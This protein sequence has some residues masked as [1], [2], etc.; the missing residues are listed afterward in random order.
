MPKYKTDRPF[1]EQ[2]L[3]NMDVI[4]DPNPSLFVDQ[5]DESYVVE[6]FIN[7]SERDALSKYFNDNFD[8]IGDNINDHVLHITYPMLK[9]EIADIVKPK[10]MEHFG[11][12]VVFYSDVAK[13]DPMSVGDQFFLSVQPYGLH[14]DAVT[15][16]NGYRPY[17]DIIIPI[18]LDSIEET[19]YVTFNQRYRGRATHFMR[20]R[21]KGSFANYANVIR[22]MSY[23]EYGVEGTEHNKK[24]LAI[25]EKI[26]PSHIPMSI[27]EDLSIEKI[28]KWK[29]KDAIIHDSSVLHAPADFRT[30]GAK[31]KTGI[32][33][34]L[35]KADPTYNNRLEGYYTPFS[36]YTK[37][38][39]KT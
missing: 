26:M 6:D 27:Y 22:H 13:D 36:R 8:S 1:S 20:G 35:M 17:K 9:K 30:Q 3:V 14:T 11:D 33:L 24:D 12:D 32:T 29:P 31:F 34:H 28:L 2:E 21:K 15:H 16:I 39:I 7:D 25:L 4:H 38:L 19:H 23:E 37:P 10:I 18:K 5:N